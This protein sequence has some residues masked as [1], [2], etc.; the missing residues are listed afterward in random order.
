M[1]KLTILTFIGILFWGMAWCAAAQNVW[2][3]DWESTGTLK[4]GKSWDAAFTTIQEGVDA[5]AAASGGEVWVAEGTYK[6]TISSTDTVVK[7]RENVSLYGGFKGIGAG[8][9]EQSRDQRNWAANKTI[10]DGNNITPCAFGASDAALDGFLIMNGIGYYD[11]KGNSY[12][13]GL[14]LKNIT[15]FFILNCLFRGNSANGKSEMFG[16]ACG[17]GI[18]SENSRVFIANSIFHNNYA[19]GS[20]Y[21]Y[22]GA[23]FADAASTPTIMNCTFYGNDVDWRESIHAISGATLYLPKS[24]KVT[25]SIIWYSPLV[26]PV[27]GL[28]GDITYCDI[29]NPTSTAAYPGTGNVNRNPRFMNTGDFHL[30]MDSPCIDAGTSEGAPLTDYDGHLRPIDITGRGLSLVFD[31]GAYEFQADQ[32]VTLCV[33]SLYGYP[34]PSC[35]THL[36]EKGLAIEAWMSSSPFTT[37]EGDIYK[38]TGWKGEGSVP[39]SGTNTYLIFNIDKPSTITWQWGPF[40]KY[41]LDVHVTPENSGDVMGSDGQSPSGYYYEN[42]FIDLYAFAA[43][44]YCFDKWSG[45]SSSTK[46]TL[47]VFITSNTTITAN[48]VRCFPPNTGVWYVDWESTATL[49]DGKTWDTAFTTIRE[50]VDA[51]AE[52]GGGEVWV[53][54][55]TYYNDPQK[56]LPVVQM[57]PWTSIYGGFIGIGSVPGA[58]ETRRE[59]R[60]WSLHKTIIDRNPSSSYYNCNIN[61]AS[62]TT[63][64]GFVI[65]NAVNYQ[66]SYDVNQGGAGIHNEDVSNSNIVNC[67][68]TSNEARGEDGRNAYHAMDFATP[69]QNGSG[70][71]IYCCQSNINIM[72]CVFSNNLA[73]G[74][75][76]GCWYGSSWEGGGSG[77]G[78]AIYHG[79]GSL[80]ISNSIFYSN[81]TQ[82]GGGREG[83][84]GCG[85]AIYS[86]SGS[87]KILNCTFWNN[88]SSSSIGKCVYVS[89]NSVLNFSN[90][91][92]WHCSPDS[93]STGQQST[94]LVQY[95]DIEGGYSGP[96]NINIDPQFVNPSVGDFHLQYGSPCIDTGTSVSLSID[97]D[98]YPRPADVPGVGADNTGW[99]FDLGAFEFQPNYASASDTKNHILGRASLP[100][101]RKIYADYNGDGKIDVADLTFLLL[102]K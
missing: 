63:I 92:I 36:Y 32:I 91:I 73:Q 69:G 54:E 40:P 87:M 58:Y 48:F 20:Y 35:G 93:I 65:Q 61:G 44:G 27:Y 45:D 98:G 10:I 62:N 7:M 80:T 17:G 55:G 101:F 25:N 38:C 66:S 102:Q 41:Y 84:V 11:E 56:N 29:E 64:D 89:S 8:G 85:G 83:A 9:Y 15:P 68:F 52:A 31:M 88:N 39:A 96:G 95:S 74:G 3:V 94:L 1:K 46:S 60:S 42:S 19:I 30:K 67:I 14:Y 57:K 97:L 4:D 28:K 33:Q 50:G 43:D 51:A 16:G 18:Y 86:Y 21:A 24:S 26:N 37:P 90:N 34:S 71:A 12:G 78:G 75:N 13:G 72:N 6:D 49:K 47:H 81:R 77:L 100:A 79:M 99:E 23:L 76:G 53:A 22:G 2:F 70:G 5:A 59:Q 82:H